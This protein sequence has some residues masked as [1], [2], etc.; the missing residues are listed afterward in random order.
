MDTTLP[1]SGPLDLIY[2]DEYI[3]AINKP[4]GL[5]THRSKIA[6]YADSF[7]LQ[8]L[9]DQLGKFVYPVHRLDRKTSGILIFALNPEMAS[10]IQVGFQEHKI[11]KKYLA[12]VRGFFPNKANT[13]YALTND[14]GKVQEATTYFKNLISSELKIRSDRYPTSRYSLVEALPITGRMHQIRKHLSHLNH[15][16]IGDRPH[17][18]N[19]QNRFFKEH[20]N[21]QSMLLH[22]YN[23]NFSHPIT[24]ELIQLRAEPPVEFKRMLNELKLK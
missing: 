22:A 1:I 21:M 3:V 20:F 23:V 17:G 15:P 10:K 11:E 18:C 19:K 8:M 24:E 13:E 2:Q 6:K 9:R 16:I 4:C 5:L 12:I 14:E 7:A